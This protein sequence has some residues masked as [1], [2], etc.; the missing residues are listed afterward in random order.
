MHGAA[1]P[2]LWLSPPSRLPRARWGCVAA[3]LLAGGRAGAHADEPMAPHDLWRSWNLEPWLLVLFALAIAL[4]ARGLARLWARAGTHRGIARWQALCYGLGILL[5]LVALVSPLDPLGETLSA[6]HMVQHMLLIIAAPFL[7]LATPLPVYLWA[8]PLSWRRALAGG[9]RRPWFASAWRLLTRPLVAWV[10][11]AAALWVWHAPVFYQAALEIRLLH[12]LEHFSFLA[13]ALL[14]WWVVLR[15]SARGTALAL[16]FTT[17]LHGGQLAAL[18]SFTP[19]PWYPAYAETTL[20]WG[21][22]PL[23]DQQLAGLIMWVPG[24]LSYLLASLALLGLWLQRLERQPVPADAAAP[25]LAPS[26]G[27]TLPPQPQQE[28]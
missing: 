6:A 19:T 15:T 22:T 8:L 20:A 10:L 24:G 23:E 4:Y 1:I 14:F 28:N 21:L 17:M 3:A 5:L 13:T 11:Y 7:V 25:K 12:D 16:L 2:K 18:M 27:R 26:P 9:A